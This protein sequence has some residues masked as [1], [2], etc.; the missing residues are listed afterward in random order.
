MCFKY[1]IQAQA[2]L[3]ESSQKLDLL[4]LSLERRLLELPANH[5]KLA[6]IKEE[7]TVGA[8][9]NVGLQRDRQ[10]SSPS[11]SSSS[12]FK[13]ASLTGIFFFPSQRSVMY[14]ISYL[15]LD[16]QLH[17]IHRGCC[18]I[19]LHSISKFQDATA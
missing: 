14:L 12:F 3:E 10:R 8:S 16:M 5:P 4:R 9:P 15:L 7:L 13:P 18:I 11:A 1:R 6:D 17:I 19:N 2:R